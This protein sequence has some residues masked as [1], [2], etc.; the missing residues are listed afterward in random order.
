MDRPTSC[1]R[2]DGRDRP[3]FRITYPLRDRPDG[4]PRARYRFPPRGNTLGRLS[5]AQGRPV[6]PHTRTRAC[7]RQ[8]PTRRPSARRTTRAS[9]GAPT[10]AD[11]PNALSAPGS[12][13][14]HR[15]N[16]HT[17]PPAAPH[18]LRVPRARAAH[19][20]ARRE[21]AEHRLSRLRSR[22]ASGSSGA[23]QRAPLQLLR[24]SF[25]QP[26]RRPRK[27]AC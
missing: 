9:D 16:T 1:H 20:A 15:A 5:L 11:A 25:R 13:A 3:T 18:H 27:R 10:H 12:L 7:P 8:R 6:R 22:R 26:P 19:A 21:D 14:Q 17:L 4:T 23:R 2:W 24:R